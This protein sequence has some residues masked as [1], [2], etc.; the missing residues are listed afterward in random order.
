M[1]NSIKVLVA[2]TCL[3]LSSYQT[4]AQNDQVTDKIIEIG[5]NDN[6]TMEYLDI[7]CNRIGGRPIG[8]DA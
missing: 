8:S 4:F 5:M 6:R 7:L 3:F 1:V 2:L